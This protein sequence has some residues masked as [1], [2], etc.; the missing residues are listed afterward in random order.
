MSDKSKEEFLPELI[1]QLKSDEEK[2]MAVEYFS[3]KQKDK[4]NHWLAKFLSLFQF[5]KYYAITLG[6]TTYYSCNKNDI[7]NSWRAHEN[8]HKEQYARDGWIK[9]I[10]RYIW[11]AITKG[12]YNID[13]EIEAFEAARK[14]M[15]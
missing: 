3:I 5:Y 7:D 1:T 10:S 14:Q 4:Y 6:Q 9:F 2:I 8:K 15:D 12:Y 13:Y 11:Q